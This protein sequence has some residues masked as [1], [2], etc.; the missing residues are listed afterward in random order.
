MVSRTKKLIRGGHTIG[1]S[2][3]RCKAYVSQKM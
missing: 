3:N 2:A 1:H